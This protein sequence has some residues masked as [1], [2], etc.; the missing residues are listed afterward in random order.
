METVQLEQIANNLMAK[1]EPACVE[2]LNQGANFVAT[3]ALYLVIIN[4][5]FFM[6]C[7]IG[8]IT[9]LN[10]FRN[11]IKEVKQLES[12]YEVEI[13]EMDKAFGDIRHFCELDYPVERKGKT[14]VVKLIKECSDRRRKAKDN[15]E[16]LKP[17]IAY[18]DAH[19]KFVQD[20]GAVAN[21][22]K[23]IERKQQGRIY[24]PRILK[25]LFSE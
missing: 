4:I 18:I 11:L 14:K 17:L 22:M 7:F 24:R 12:I 1:L 6:V 3:E 25:E 8:I 21:E 2:V 10:E 5:V 16:I 13:N 23:N 20:I 19:P 9:L 15:L